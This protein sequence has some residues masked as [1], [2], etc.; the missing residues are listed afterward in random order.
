MP[1]VCSASADPFCPAADDSG[2]MGGFLRQEKVEKEGYLWSDI[3]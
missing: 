2:K 3:V 1:H